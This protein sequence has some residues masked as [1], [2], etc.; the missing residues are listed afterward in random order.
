MPLN[1]ELDLHIKAASAAGMEEGVKFLVGMRIGYN[2]LVEA[3][4]L[5]GSLEEIS[6]GNSPESGAFDRLMNPE[7]NITLREFLKEYRHTEFYP[8]I[9]QEEAAKRIGISVAWYQKLEQGKGNP[10]L[11]TLTRIA[12]GFSFHPEMTDTFIR[13]FAPK[14]G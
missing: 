5:P 8:P 9:S 3:R 12:Y 4:K 11:G 2:A 6:E 7:D 14:V 13:K 10:Q 1:I